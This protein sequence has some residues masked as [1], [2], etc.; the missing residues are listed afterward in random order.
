M[1]PA[2]P[3]AAASRGHAQHPVAAPT[4]YVAPGS[5]EAAAGLFFGVVFFFGFS[6]A[7]VQSL[8]QLSMQL[9]LVSPTQ[10][11]CASL[12]EERFVL[13]QAP[14]QSEPGPSLSHYLFDK[15]NQLKFKSPSPREKMRGRF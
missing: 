13:A 10:S 3:A 11:L 8:L 2:C 5:S 7:F 6:A 9:F 1:C 4:P 14:Q 15:Q 12:L